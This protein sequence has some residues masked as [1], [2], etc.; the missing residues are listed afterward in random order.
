MMGLEKSIVIVTGAGNGIGRAMVSLFHA[1]GASVIAADIDAA[2]LTVLARD[3]PDVN[4][5]RADISEPRGADDIIA[6]AQGHV[7][8]LCNNAGVSDGSLLVDETTDA[9]WTTCLAVNLTGTFLLCRRA[10]PIMVAQNRGIIVNTAS[11]AG[12]RGGKGGAAY[13]A[14]KFGVIGLTQN[15]A[16]SY[17]RHGIKC[18]AICPGPVDTQL[19]V[20]ALAPYSA[21]GVERIRSSG[22]IPERAAPEQVAAIAVMLAQDESGLING[23]AIP[24]EDGWL[25][26]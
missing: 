4:V 5:V 25:A 16:A 19:R 12:V 26:W 18:N 2:A 21:Q 6:A 8:I 24:A 14:A 10:L 20:K 3:L 22:G 7:D 11:V 15:I 9:D 13:A 17:S 1:R 23:A